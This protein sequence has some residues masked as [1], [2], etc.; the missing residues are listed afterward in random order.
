MIKIEKLHEMWKKDS[1]IDNSEL[2]AS[3]IQSAILHSK[4]LELYNMT[5]LNLK[6][7][8]L[9]YESLKHR[10]WRYYTGKMEKVEMDELGWDYDPFNGSTKPLKS[11]INNYID[12]D[13]DIQKLSLKIEYY[14]V[15]GEALE[16]IISTLKWRHQTIRNI[17]E[18]RK[19]TSGV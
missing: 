17:I 10:K 1:V 5:R 8:Q 4:Y 12:S 18:F 6:K 7:K 19:F 2:D 3:S 13:K 11:E 14:K 15:V 9:E 16:E